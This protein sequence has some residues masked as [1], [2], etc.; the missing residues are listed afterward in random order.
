M[1]IRFR[2]KKWITAL[3]GIGAA[4]AT[5]VGAVCFALRLVPVLAAG[6]DTTAMIA[7]G[8]ILP[9]GAAHALVGEPKQDGFP[10]PSSPLENASSDSSIETPSILDS[11]LSSASSSA[12]SSAPKQWTGKAYPIQ[13]LEMANTG[14]TYGNIVVKNSSKVHKVDIPA[15]LAQ[16]PDVHIKKDG[17]P[18]V[19]IYHTHTTESYMEEESDTY[20]SD[21][22]TRTQDNNL[23]V[24]RVGEEIAKRLREAGIGVVHDTTVHD[25]PSYSGSYDR[26]IETMRKNLE[27]YPTIQVTLDIHRDAL[28]G[29]T[30][31]KPTTTV[32]GKKAAQIMIISGCDDDGSLGFPD[33]EYNL[34][35][36]MRLQQAGAEYDGQLM[37][38]L[39]FTPSKYNEHMTH[40]SLLVEFGTEV[41][42]I[43][44]AVYSGQLFG[45]A[46]VKVLNELVD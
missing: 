24:V 27:Q 21:M 25:Y 44:E 17:T 15:V 4:A 7:A 11:S 9:G 34:R 45:D 26:S 1:L 12:S 6:G 2:Q 42:T 5:A 13:E 22:P 23:N 39:N 32:N 31:L 14:V 3:A 18:Q 41:S 46:L 16:R 29:D 10:L 36:A 30:R 19:L 20:F 38:P 43:D 8:F 28:G 40:G 35:L 33:W 37:R